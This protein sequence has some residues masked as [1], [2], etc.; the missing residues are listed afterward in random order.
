MTNNYNNVLFLKL[1]LLLPHVV[2]CE[3]F[4]SIQI[5]LSKQYYVFFISWQGLGFFKAAPELHKDGE[6]PSRLPHNGSS[7]E[8]A[9]ATITTIKGPASGDAG[10]VQS[11]AHGSM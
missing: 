8:R 9:P 3:C 7:K 11:R 10:G 2:E 6:G 5:S 1:I 4:T